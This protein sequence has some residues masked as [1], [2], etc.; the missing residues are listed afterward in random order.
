MKMAYL[1]MKFDFEEF[2]KGKMYM[3]KEARE[4]YV[5]D[6][7]ERKETDEYEGVQ[8]KLEIKQDTYKYPSK[9]GEVEG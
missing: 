9:N 7:K 5:W 1:F 3:I 8:L 2:N 6:S 4:K